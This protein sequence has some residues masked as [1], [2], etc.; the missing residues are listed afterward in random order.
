MVKKTPEIGVPVE[1]FQFNPSK[2]GKNSV[3]LLDWRIKAPEKN[4]VDDPLED[5]QG[6]KKSKHPRK[7]NNVMFRV[8]HVDHIPERQKQQKIQNLEESVKWPVSQLG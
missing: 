4:V 1:T 2:Y 6:K 7:V 3:N 8:S 5:L